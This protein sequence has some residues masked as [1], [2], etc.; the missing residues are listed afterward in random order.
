MAQRNNIVFWMWAQQA[1]GPG[2]GT[3]WHIYKSFPGG[4]EGFYRAGPRCWNRLDYVSEVQTESLAVC[5]AEEAMAR[6]EY[7]LRL[8][9]QAVTPECEQYPQE[10]RN[11]SDPPAVLYIK[12]AEPRG[13]TGPKVAVA[14]A[15]KALPESLDAARSIGYQLATAGGVVVTGEAVGVDAGVMEGVIAA[16]GRAICVLPVDLSSPYMAKTAHLRRRVLEQG[17]ALMTE[18]F[19]QRSPA[20][21]GFQL[22]NRLITGLCP[23][24]VLIQ[25]AEK[26][27]TMIYARHAAGQGRRLYVFPGPEGAGEFAGSR[28]LLREGAVPVYSGSEVLGTDRAIAMEAPTAVKS[29][30]GEPPKKQGLPERQELSL[31][32]QA[33]LAQL[34]EGPHTVDELTEGCGMDP[35]KLLRLLTRMEM[36]GL[37]ESAPGRRYSRPLKL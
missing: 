35:G 22:R 17:G 33:V 37:I 4:L 14:G 32:Q 3:P 13:L 18:Y 15:R 25:A 8:G 11:I 34:E 24:V 28:R 2:S 12:G 29:P 30:E 21:G 6:L 26:S 20:Q 5:T 19:S 27:G 1:F 10:L 36:Q 31:E 16:G 9:W 23:K 7:A